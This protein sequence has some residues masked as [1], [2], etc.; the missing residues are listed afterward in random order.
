MSLT[1]QYL[2]DCLESR[3][4]GPFDFGTASVQRWW[5]DWIVGIA[6]G[7]HLVVRTDANNVGR[8]WGR[9]AGIRD[10]L[11]DFW[12]RYL[13]HEVPSIVARVQSLADLKTEHDPSDTVQYYFEQAMRCFAMGLPEASIALM[14]A[15][16]ENALRD[17]LPHAEGSQDL[18]LLIKWAATTRMLDPAHVQMAHRIRLLGNRVMHRG[19]C[20]SDNAFEAATMLRA[21]VGSL[22][23]IRPENLDPSGFAR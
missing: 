12:C 23:V 20:T 9:A 5:L 8:I 21:V 18:E 11:D 14:R 16:L 3:K 15:C 6:G 19:T 7:Q 22:Y 1:S 2:L 10:L 13:L 4:E 17:A